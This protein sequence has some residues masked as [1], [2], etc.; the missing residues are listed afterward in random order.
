VASL[1]VP[2]LVVVGDSDQMIPV[3]TAQ[4]LATA[5]PDGAFELV[6][7]AGHLVSL[8]RPDEFNR[9]LGR[10]MERL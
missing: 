6:E 5:A 2:L 4:E 10:F 9:A 3:E 1:A 7:G 8:E